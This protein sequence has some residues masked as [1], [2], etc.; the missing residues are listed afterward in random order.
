MVT[1][2]HFHA[3]AN[4]SLG[5]INLNRKYVLLPSLTCDEYVRLLSLR[6][7]LEDTPSGSTTS[8]TFLT[9]KKRN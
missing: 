4:K 5:R 7:F 6:F 9:L 8:N 2:Y 1:T 3:Y